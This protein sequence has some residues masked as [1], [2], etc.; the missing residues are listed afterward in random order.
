MKQIVDNPQK[1]VVES[2]T[3]RLEPTPRAEAV[4]VAY[5]HK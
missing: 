1:I 3:I 5:F 2:L 4:L